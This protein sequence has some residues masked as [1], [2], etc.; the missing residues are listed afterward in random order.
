MTRFKYTLSIFALAGAVAGCDSKDWDA[1][2]Y[3]DGYAT[4]VSASCD[5]KAP[6][7]DGKYDKFKYAR[8][9]ARGAKAAA[10]DIQS[11]GCEAFK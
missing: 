8:G 9:Y 4:T 3:K 5:L 1:A 2:G 6:L 10:V 11:K 7:V